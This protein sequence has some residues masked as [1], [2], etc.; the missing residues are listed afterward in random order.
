MSYLTWGLCLCL[1]RTRYTGSTYT[2]DI[3]KLSFGSG[4]P[5]WLL[6]LTAVSHSIYFH[7]A[8][9]LI[10]T[11]ISIFSLFLRAPCRILVLKKLILYAF[12]LIWKSSPVRPILPVLKTFRFC[13]SGI[14]CISGK[15][16]ICRSL[17]GRRIEVRSEYRHQS[18]HIACRTSASSFR[19]RR[20]KFQSP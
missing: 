8:L 18:R 13:L 4:Q 9:F 17:L 20:E 7:F 6:L 2:Q 19:C 14:R 12:G 1:C 3:N 10:S 5:G 16:K 11:F 15:E